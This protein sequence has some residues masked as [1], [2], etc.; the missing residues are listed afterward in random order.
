MSGLFLMAFAKMY[1]NGFL[2]KKE[3]NMHVLCIKI[4]L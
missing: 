4:V 1:V 3:G 2:H